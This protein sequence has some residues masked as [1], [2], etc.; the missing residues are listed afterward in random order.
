MR[1]VTVALMLALFGHGVFADGEAEYKYREGVMRTVGGHMSS[2]VAILRGRV[3][4]DDLAFHARGMA[5]MARIVPRVFPEG[6]GVAKSE[7]LPD[8]W[9]KPDEFRQA[10]DR[11]V[12]AANGMSE[13][14]GSGD[15]SAIGPAIDAL[16]K[17]C[18]NCHD[19][20]REEEDH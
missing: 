6:S 5:D 16:G 18:K 1:S 15:M 19:H 8:I 14:A 13:A 10:V 9:E 11:F 12:K 7:A 4:M 2:M 3:H 20:F 17:S